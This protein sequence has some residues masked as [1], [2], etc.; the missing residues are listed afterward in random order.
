MRC[1]LNWSGFCFP[2]SLSLPLSLLCFSL[3]HRLDIIYPLTYSHLSQSPVIIEH[4]NSRDSPSISIIV[5][6]IKKNSSF[7][8]FFYVVRNR[9]QY[10]LFRYPWVPAYQG[11]LTFFV[12]A[13]FGLATF[14]DPGVIPKG[15]SNNRQQ[16]NAFISTTD[17]IGKTKVQKNQFIAGNNEKNCFFFL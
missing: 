15:K 1:P 12:I 7:F 2:I 5:N 11:V 13:N 17:N 4:S 10:Y 8:L 14:M 6:L 16:Q 9:C 3:S